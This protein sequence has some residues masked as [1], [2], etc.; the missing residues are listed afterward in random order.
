MNVVDIIEDDDVTLCVRVEFSEGRSALLKIHRS[1][2][3]HVHQGQPFGRAEAWAA[4][5]HNAVGSNMFRS[6]FIHTAAAQEKIQQK[7]I[8]SL[9]KNNNILI[10]QKDR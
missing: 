8:L 5:V 4:V 1:S 2:L 6:Y 9:C 10:K 3:K 7:T